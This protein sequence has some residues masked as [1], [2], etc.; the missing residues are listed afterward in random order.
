MDSKPSGKMAVIPPTN[1]EI[2]TIP[3]YLLDELKNEIENLRGGEELLSWGLGLIIGILA[4]TLFIA[5]YPFGIIPSP[6]SQIVEN[7]QPYEIII[8]LSFI[9][10][11]YFYRELYEKHKEQDSGLIRQI[12]ENINLARKRNP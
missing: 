6:K 1:E 4:T 9:L 2:V 5:F 12:L 3:R 7:T 10:L 8:I 11:L